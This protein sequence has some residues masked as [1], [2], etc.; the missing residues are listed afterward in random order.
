MDF[1]NYIVQE[2]INERKNNVKIK[3]TE[4]IDKMPSILEENYTY[5]NNGDLTFT[6]MNVDWGIDQKTFSNAAAYA[7]L[8][9]DGQMDLDSNKS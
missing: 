7:D 1:L 9:N 6:K 5:K 2:K 3:L 4:L 8:N